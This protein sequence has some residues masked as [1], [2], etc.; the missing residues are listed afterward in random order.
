MEEKKD[1]SKELQSLIM[2]LAFSFEKES[3]DKNR[4]LIEELKTRYTENTHLYMSQVE[5][6]SLQ[7]PRIAAMP[8]MESHDLSESKNRGLVPY[9]FNGLFSHYIR[10][11]IEKNEG[12]PCSGDKEHF[13]I[14]K[15]FKAIEINEN[16]DLYQTYD[17]CDRIPKEDWDKQAYWSPKTIKDTDTAIKMFYDWYNLN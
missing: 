1:M 9:L 11:Y 10:K 5:L 6:A 8:Y 3:N 13:I 15:V 12:T 16:I 2:D 14:N 7:M 17:G 4:E